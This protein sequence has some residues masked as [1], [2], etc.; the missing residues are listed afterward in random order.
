MI[1]SSACIIKLTTKV[2]DIILNYWALV[3]LVFLPVTAA[4]PTGM[5]FPNIPFSTFSQV[6]EEQF[7]SDVTLATVFTILLSLIHNT[8]M[9]NL[10]ARQQTPRFPGE[11][12]RTATGWMKAF[13]WSLHKH[14][15]TIDSLFTDADDFSSLGYDAQV[16]A[17]AQKMNVLVHC[18]GLSPYSQDGEFQGWIIE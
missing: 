14:L 16:S 8:D 6:I 17:A 5:P 1:L 10:H 13:I 9:L 7:S 2:F 12:K 3:L 18:L 4:T 15:G 11:H